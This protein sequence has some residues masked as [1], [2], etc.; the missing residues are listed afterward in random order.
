MLQGELEQHRNTAANA[1]QELYGHI[2][3]VRRDVKSSDFDGDGFN[4]GVDSNVLK[5]LEIVEKQLQLRKVA[6]TV[7]TAQPKIFRDKQ[8]SAIKVE[9]TILDM[10]KI[11]AEIN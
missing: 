8:T 4:P 9:D 1:F 3:K 11:F 6:D 10:M 7:G 5:R 2:E